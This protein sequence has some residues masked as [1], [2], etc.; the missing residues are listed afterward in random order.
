[1]SVLLGKGLNKLLHKFLLLSVMLG[2]ALVGY[3]NYKGYLT[4]NQFVSATLMA[5]MSISTLLLLSRSARYEVVLPSMNLGKIA[6]ILP[7]ILFLCA[8]SELRLHG[9]LGLFS[10]ITLAGIY[11][12]LVFSKSD[13][14]VVSTEVATLAALIASL[15][16]VYTPSFGNDTWRDAIQ[17]T[18]VIAR[19]GLKDLTIAHPAYLILLVPL[20]YTTYGIV[21]GLDTLW[22]SSCLVLY[23]LIPITSCFPDIHLKAR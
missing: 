20:L 13:S 11:V 1:M 15:Y 9:H 3:Y 12:V 22:S 7:C 2:Y 10:V 18:Q 21:T 4:L 5:L 16:G 8:F 17:A 19:G 14:A 6:Y 23:L